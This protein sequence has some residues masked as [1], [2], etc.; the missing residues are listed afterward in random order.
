M[1]LLLFARE[2]CHFMSDYSF[3]WVKCSEWLIQLN[4]HQHMQFHSSRTA[5]FQKRKSPVDFPLLLPALA[6]PIYVL[7]TSHKYKRFS[8]HL[9][10]NIT[11]TC[12]HPSN[13]GDFQ[14]KPDDWGSHLWSVS[15]L[16]QALLGEA[17]AH[18]LVTD[19]VAEQHISCR[20]NKTCWRVGKSE[21]N[22]IYQ[23]LSMVC[24][25]RRTNQPISP[26]ANRHQ[27]WRVK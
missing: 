8:S 6:N 5:S 14:L 17:S 10:V 19:C 4:I 3:M 22:C 20:L 26:R 24:G 16:Q 9:F 7:R 13:R 1:P 21:S 27:G 18:S 25:V 11:L 15:L 23:E 12:W 2:T